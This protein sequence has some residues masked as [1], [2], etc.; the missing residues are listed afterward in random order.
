MDAVVA[1]ELARGLDA[2]PGGGDLDEHALAR[3]AEG[4]VERD[5]FF[6]LCF[7]QFTFYIQSANPFN[8]NGIW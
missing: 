3:D 7:L 8:I 5:E 1:L 2:V 6:G 4:L